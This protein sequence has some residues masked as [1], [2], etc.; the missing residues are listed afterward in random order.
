MPP[1]PTLGPPFV[2]PPFIPPQNLCLS[3]LLGN[4]EHILRQR[5]MSLPVKPPN[6]SSHWELPCFLAS[7]DCYRYHQSS[8]LLAVEVPSSFL[9]VSTWDGSFKPHPVERLWG[10]TWEDARGYRQCWMSE[11]ISPHPTAIPLDLFHVRLHLENCSALEIEKKKSPCSGK[12][13]PLSPSFYLKLLRF[14]HSCPPGTE[15]GKASLLSQLLISH[16]LG[17]GAKEDYSK[18]GLVHRERTAGCCSPDSSRSSES[19]RGLTW[20]RH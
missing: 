8:T 1:H 17:S 4:A 3:S 20:N 19:S 15:V 7:L 5:V 12:P 14:D 18:T 16:S 9:T 13:K 6:D 11:A 2:T 10:A